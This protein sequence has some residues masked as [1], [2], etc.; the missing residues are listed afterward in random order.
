MS[1]RIIVLLRWET[2]YPLLCWENK[3]KALNRNNVIFVSPYL[4]KERLK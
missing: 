1:R 4:P 3:I 2:A